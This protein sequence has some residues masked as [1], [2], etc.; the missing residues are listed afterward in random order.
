MVNAEGGYNGL[1]SATPTPTVTKSTTTSRTFVTGTGTVICAS[2]T[3]AINDQK[4]TVVDIQVPLVG[5]VVEAKL[6]LNLYHSYPWDL[7]GQ[8]INPQGVSARLFKDTLCHQER[9]LSLSF[10]DESQQLQVDCLTASTAQQTIKPMTPLSALL[11]RSEG[12]WKIS[13]SDEH[14]L[15]SGMFNSYCLELKVAGAPIGWFYVVEKFSQYTDIHRTQLR[16][17]R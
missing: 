10:D 16:M 6:S 15:D 7:H 5:E 2:P 9:T 11:G 12:I 3:I 4:S 1:V 13:I 14:A 17:R 8:L